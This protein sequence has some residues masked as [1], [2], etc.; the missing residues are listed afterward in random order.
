MLSTD[1]WAYRSP[2]AWA[3]LL[4]VFALGLALDLGSKAWSF[5]A[6][7]GEPVY[8]D[9]ETILADR[10]V[11]PVPPH[12]SVPALPGGLLHFHLVVNHGAVFG[13]GA[14][15]R[16]FFIAFTL[17]A[18]LVAMIVFGRYT[19]SRHHMA[20]VALGL[21]LAGGIG[22][23]YDRVAYGVVRDFLHMLPNYRLPFDWRWPGGSPHMFP[24]V[25]NI[26][27]IMLL[28]GMG[29]L[30]WH[31]NR[32]ERSRRPETNTAALPQQAAWHASD[33]HSTTTAADDGPDDEPDDG[34]NAS[35]HGGSDAGVN[36]GNGN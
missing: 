16:F 24:W 36:N 19:K 18:L 23:L 21:I 1:R 32:I 12:A 6:V 34:R 22:N 8:L 35:W 15:Q 11:N 30:L 27:D 29:T 5:A 3:V 17:A 7:A 14:D 10:T 2:R 13:I 9:R 20:H 4:I 26:A 31:I 25:F 33:Q 28:I